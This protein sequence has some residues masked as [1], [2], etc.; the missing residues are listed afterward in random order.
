MSI[1]PRTSLLCRAGSGREGETCRRVGVGR[2]GVRFPIVLVLDFPPLFSSEGGAVGK[3]RLGRSQSLVLDFNFV[4][5]PAFSVKRSFFPG[6]SRDGL[7]TVS[8]VSRLIPLLRFSGA[9]RQAC[10]QCEKPGSITST[11]TI[12]KRTPTRPYVDP[13]TRFLAA[14]TDT[15]SSLAQKLGRELESFG[16]QGAP[17]LI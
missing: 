2:V 14:S 15:S 9:D 13:P 12:G 10:G 8:K 3:P 4:H 6:T 5:R 1:H 16:Q 17:I 11:I 7:P